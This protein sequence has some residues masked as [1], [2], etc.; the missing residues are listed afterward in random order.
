[1]ETTTTVVSDRSVAAAVRPGPQARS[2]RSAVQP[3]RPVVRLDLQALPRDQSVQ[4]GQPVLPRD[5]PAWL[6][7]RSTPAHRP[8]RPSC[9]CS[10]TSR[11]RPQRAR[12]RSVEPQFYSFIP[13]EIA[14]PLAVRCSHGQRSLA[15][16]RLVNKRAGMLQLRQSRTK[17]SYP[18]ATTSAHFCL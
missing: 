17:P 7:D 10:C 6:R 12:A 16:S 2:G 9:S 8:V 18:F 15:A 14:S 5:Q 11:L 13:P 4:P 1:M 3:D